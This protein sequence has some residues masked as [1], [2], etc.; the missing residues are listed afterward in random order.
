[1]GF[2]E[3]TKAEYAWKLRQGAFL[4]KDIHS[5]Q[6]LLLC[7]PGL[8]ELYTGP[9]LQHI[10]YLPGP[11]SGGP[12][13]PTRSSGSYR[14]SFAFSSPPVSTG[15]GSV[16]FCSL[17]PSPEYGILILLGKLGNRS[18]KGKEGESSSMRA[19]LN[20]AGGFEFWSNDT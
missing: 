7:H 14:G 20:A 12:G 4:R 17:E 1:M 10:A 18:S 15:F 9:R 2:E 13:F 11:H 3:D 8:R 5:L 16:G 19:W 6:S